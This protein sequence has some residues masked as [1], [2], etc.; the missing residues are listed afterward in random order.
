MKKSTLLKTAS[1]VTVFSVCERGLGFLYRILLS[2]T[3]GSEGVGLYQ[4]ALSVFAVFATLVSSGIPVT[5]SRLIPKYRTLG[6]SAAER[7]TVSAAVLCTLLAAIPLFLLVYLGH[8]LVDS[9]FS[10]PR[11]GKIFLILMYGFVFNAVYAVLRGT[12]WGNK[13]FLAYSVIEFVEEAVMIAVGALLIL[14]ADSATDGAERAAFAVVVSYLTS[15][16][17]ALIYFFA[18]GGKFVRAGRENFRPLLSAALPV[19]AMRTSTSVVSSLVSLLLPA[20]LIAGGLTAAQAMSEY[21]VALGMAIPILYTPATVIGSLALVLTPELSEHFYRKNH[22][23]LQQSLER[24]LQATV[25][26]SCTLIP[27][28]FVFG[29]DMGMLIY[30]SARSGELIGKACGMLLPMSLAMITTSMLNSL[31]KEKKTLLYYF[32][33]AAAMLACVWGLAPFVGIYA[34]L[35]GQCAN[36]TVCC[37]MNLRLIRK[38]CVRPPAYRT[39]LLLS[40]LIAG[41]EMLVGGLLYPFLRERMNVWFAIALAALCMLAVQATGAL[42]TGTY[43]IIVPKSKKVHQSV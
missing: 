1:L 18:K 24:A 17:L 34:L 6:N 3:L 8:G 14:G 31:G 35:I 25:L 20:R 2:R 19:T 9:F 39:F 16:A 30:A 27:L 42:L 29:P 10:D 40:I 36:H 26:V 32:L 23:S 4:L 43:K 11:C 7:Q 28:F 37:L 22:R 33:G 38:T 21:G 41:A 15:F 5:L 12:F 13:Q